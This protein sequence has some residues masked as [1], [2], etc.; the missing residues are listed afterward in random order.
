MLTTLIVSIVVYGVVLSYWL[1]R[2]FRR[3][4]KLW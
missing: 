1:V 3:I 2:L 4:N